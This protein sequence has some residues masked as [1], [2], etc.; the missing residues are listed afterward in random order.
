MRTQQ[1][2]LNLIQNAINNSNQYGK[3]RITL[4]PVNENKSYELKF[5][6]DKIDLEILVSDQGLGI[7]ESDQI[8][9]FEPYFLN[10]ETGK[11]SHGL[12]L[13]TCKQIA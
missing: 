1:I 9:L 13:C 6:N 12:G 5:D 2:L 4:K 3:I 7:S 8:D 11:V 10:Q